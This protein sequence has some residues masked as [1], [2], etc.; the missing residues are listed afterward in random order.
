VIVSLDLSTET[1]KQLLLPQ[2]F[3]EVPWTQPVLRV[4]MNCLCFSHVNRKTEF[5]LWQMKDYGVQKSWTQLF[6]ISYQN[7]PIAIFKLVCL[8]KNGDMVIIVNEHSYHAVIYNLRDKT[9]ETFRIKNWLQRYSNAK[10][11]VESFVSVPLN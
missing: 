4:M 3:D 9:A 6:K 5:V 7:I 10:D 8:Y 2:G 1:Y 11:Y